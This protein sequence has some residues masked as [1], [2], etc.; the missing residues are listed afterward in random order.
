MTM[1]NRMQTDKAP[2][3]M[4]VTDQV[5]KTKSLHGKR[6]NQAD[7]RL[8]YVLDWKDVCQ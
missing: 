1:T 3:C 5:V 7:N 2:C 6:I 8:G 4:A